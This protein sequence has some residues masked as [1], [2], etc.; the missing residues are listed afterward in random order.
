MIKFH[1][2]AGVQIAEVTDTEFQISSVQDAVDLLGDLYFNNCSNIILR[3]GNLHPDFFRLHTGLAGDVLQKYSNYS[4]RL[5]IIGDF[6][7]YT[8][9]SLQDFIRECNRG[10]RVFFV[11]SIEEALE[12]LK[13]KTGK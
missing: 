8:S 7:K 10:N 9:K 6:S 11:A 13:S 1:D 4:C 3:E 2:I 12:R 5:A